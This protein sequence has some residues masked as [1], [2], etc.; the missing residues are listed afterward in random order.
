[1]TIKEQIIDKLKTK[2]PGIEHSILA[3]V[4]EK[5]STNTTNEAD[6]A[7]AVEGVTFQ[8]LLQ[9]YGDSRANEA[10]VSAVR[11]YESKHGL[12]DGE[13]LQGGDQQSNPTTKSTEGAQPTDETAKMLKQLLDQNKQL[14]ERLNRMDADRATATRQEKLNA[15]INRLPE[16][17]RKGYS[18]TSFDGKSDED[19]EKML[20]E[21]TSEVDG[22]VQSTKAQ[23]A[24]F[25]KPA[26][27]NTGSND[28]LTKEQEAAIAQ[29]GGI[30]SKDQQPF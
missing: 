9:S 24:V 30:V 6:V 8:S 21:I 16:A 22:I 27:N 19:F 14:T 25:G 29:R 4:A 1:M 13:K 10:S 15:V 11:N 23:G 7:T 12:K 3:R 2:F 17:L 26:S 20:T 18:R 5:L 28:A